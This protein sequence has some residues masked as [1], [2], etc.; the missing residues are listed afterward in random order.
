[1]REAL[2]YGLTRGLSAAAIILAFPLA[3]RLGLLI[4]GHAWHEYGTVWLDPR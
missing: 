3:W 2:K 4:G 1:M